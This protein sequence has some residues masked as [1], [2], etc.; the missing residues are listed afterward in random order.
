MF[1]KMPLLLL[2]PLLLIGPVA[3]GSGEKYNVLD[4][5]AKSDGATLCTE[6]I[7]NAVDQCARDGGGTVYFPAGT[8]LTG[9]V[10][11]ESHVNLW[12]DPGCVLL[13]SKEKKDY[14]RPRKLGDSRGETFSYWAII[15]GKNLE[16]IAI[17]GRGTID[18]QGANF[19]YKNGPRPKNIYLE[20]CSDVL[21]EGIH[22]RNAGSWMEHYRQCDRLTIRDVTVFN[23]VSYNNDGLN[24]DSCRDVTISGCR[25]DSDDDGVV[26]KSLSLTPCENVTIS[27]CIISSHCNSIKMGTESGGGFQNVTVTN[28]TICSPRYSKVIYGRQRGLAGV[29]LEI[30]DGGALDRVTVSNLTIKGVTVP[31]FMRL[32]NRARVYEKNQAK[33]G[34]GNFRNVIVSDVIATDCSAVGCSIT[35]LPGHAIENVTLSNIQLGFEGGGAKEAAS[36]SIAERPT[37][38]PESTMFGTLPAYGFFCRH[39]KGLRFQNLRF[40]TAAPDYRHAIVFDDVNDAVLDGLDAPLTDGAAEMVRSTN[41]RRIVIHRDNGQANQATSTPADALAIDADVPAGNIIVDRIEDDTVFLKPDLRDTSTWWFYWKFRVRGAAGRTLKFLFEGNNPIGT[42]GPAVSTD[43][44]HT[45]SWLGPKAVQKASFT[46]AFAPESREVQFCFSIP[47]LEAN[48]QK[49]LRRHADDPHLAVRELCR[50]RKGRVVERLDVGKLDGTPKYRI[51]L[52]ARHHA[53]EMIASYSLEGL[54]D[55]VLAK[56]D[57]GRWFRDNVEILAIPFVDKDGVEDGD[58][59]KNRKP[60][61]HNRDYAGESIYPSVRTIRRLVPQWS[62]GKLDLVLDLHCPYISGDYNEVIYIVGSSD[63][64]VWK[65][66]QRFAAILESVHTGELPYFAKSNLPFGTAWNTA[67]NFGGLKSCSRWGAE[68]VGVRLSTTIEIPYA[69]VGDTVVTADNARAFGRDVAVALRRYL[70]KAKD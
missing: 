63:P 37:A 58:Q 4:F 66:Q 6:A 21:I 34:I 53:C 8:W 45:W 33:P 2:S 38:Y 51:L 52:T 12:L 42:Q 57:L 36:R 5:G 50:T 56:T 68:Q 69:N 70:E 29:A 55:A 22:L 47:Y 11:L 41:S 65:Q 19:K 1:R 48:L 18:G 24:I 10:Y 39:V 49:F 13:G 25:V 64:A 44:G 59:G 35:G 14:G 32:G 27:D 26:L 60:H 3:F 67:N 23:H 62:R 9:T 46:Y 16:N 54:L 7:Q 31:I 15:A 40:Q 20:G 17:C 61:D 43:G 28:C 30:V